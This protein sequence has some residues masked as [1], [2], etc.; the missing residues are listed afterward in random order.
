M[1]D[2]LQRYLEVASG[3]TR[4]TLGA[5]ERA[6]AQFVRQGEV[7]AEH[8]ER[9]LDEVIARSVEGSGAMAQLVRTEVAH[10][11]ERAGVA[12]VDEVD[13]LRRRVDELSTR[14]AAVEEPAAA[15]ANPPPAPQEAT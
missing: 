6:V 1:S 4:T 3:L 11:L 2:E 13:D 9:L 12:R 7:A 14:L 5:T 10:A 8:A 15:A